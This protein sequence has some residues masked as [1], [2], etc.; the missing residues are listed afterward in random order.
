VKLLFT[1]KLLIKISN[2]VYGT[3]Y[4]TITVNAGRA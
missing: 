2:V 3:G 4:E 1:H